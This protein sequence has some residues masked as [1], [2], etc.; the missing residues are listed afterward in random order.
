M[1]RIKR[2]YHRV[3]EKIKQIRQRCSTALT[4]G[5]R[6]RSGKLILEHFV[7][8]DLVWCR[9]AAVQPLSY[10]ND[11]SCVYEYSFYPWRLLMKVVPVQIVALAVTLT[12]LVETPAS[13][14]P[15]VPTD[16]TRK[17]QKELSY[18]MIMTLFC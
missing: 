18:T 14:E 13:E 2:I 6:S 17:Q 8:S 10:G 3:L 16:L 1:R 15:T 7:K 5:S 4:T 12:L 11:S 9:S